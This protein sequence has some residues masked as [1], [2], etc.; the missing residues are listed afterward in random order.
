MN[1]ITKI[2]ALSI[3]FSCIAVANAEQADVP[4]NV[5][6]EKN[7]ANMDMVVKDNFIKAK[8]A[9]AE[10]RFMQGNVKTS[11]DDFN[12]LVQ[13][14]VHD[15]YVFLLYGIKMAEYGF[16]DL[17]DDLIDRLDINHFTAAYVRDMKRFYYPSGMVNENDTI[18]LADAYSNIIYNNMAL[19]TTSE[20]LNSAIAEESD[21]KNYLISLGYYKSNNLPK[22]LKYINNAIKE[23]STN[24]NYLGLKAKILADS[25]KAG[26]ALKVVEQIK[27]EPFL[28]KDFQQKVRAIEEYVLYKN[29]KPG[30]LKDYHLAYYYHLQNKSLLATKVLQSAILTSKQYSPLIF[31]LLGRIYYE[32]DEPLKAEEFA[33]RAYKEDKKNYLAVM[34]LADLSFENRHF[35]DSLMYYKKAKKLTKDSLP[36]VGIAKSYLALEQ[37]EKSKKMY[38]KMLKKEKF[39]EEL[40]VESLKIIPH[41]VDYYLPRVASIDLSNND[42]WLG[43]ANQAIKDGNFTMATTYLNNSYYIDEN[44]FRYYYY[45]SLVLRAKGDVELANQSLLRCSSI[46]SD[47]ASVVNPGNYVYEK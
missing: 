8:Y 47:Y 6:T 32:N 37:T 9:S 25:D 11:H 22:A 4:L 18:Y 30:A 2:L 12:D 26:Q 38:E 13:K 45:L 10:N 23:N 44:N 34:T 35:E 14:A 17:S 31:S 40:L 33:T 43:L 27:K 21:Y 36:E 3:V 39:N 28:T 29:A 5:R 20:L 42:I 7:V 15:D 1:K 24:V 16:F 41:R 46:N 19:E